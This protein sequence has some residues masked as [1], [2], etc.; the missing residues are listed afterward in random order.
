MCHSVLT[1]LHIIIKTFAQKIL[2]ETFPQSQIAVFFQSSI[3]STHL[4][5]VFC[6][7]TTPLNQYHIFA[8]HFSAEEEEQE[9]NMKFF[10]K[11]Y[12]KKKS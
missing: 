10:R 12:T 7:L 5:D 8:W 6:L 1:S 3:A 4:A 2:P 11:N 9:K